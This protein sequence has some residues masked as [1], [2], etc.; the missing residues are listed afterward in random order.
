MSRLGAAD[1]A[2]HPDIATANFINRPIFSRKN[3]MRVLVAEQFEA[4]KK[5]RSKKIT[6]LAGV[7]K[8]KSK[9]NAS[10]LKSNSTANLLLLGYKFA[11][12]ISA[13]VMFVKK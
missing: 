8:S 9:D 12:K 4:Q 11:P 3:R 10:T 6:I 13:S 1:P 7:I 2:S 5:Q